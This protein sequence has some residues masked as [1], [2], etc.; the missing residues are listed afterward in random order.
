MST[1][2]VYQFF[3]RAE[4]DKVLFYKHHD[5]YPDGWFGALERIKSVVVLG[6]FDDLK[7]IKKVMLDIGAEE[8]RDEMEADRADQQ[9]RYNVR[10]DDGEVT[11]THYDRHGEKSKNHYILEHTGWKQRWMEK[12]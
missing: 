8:L 3:N 7:V 10:L 12:V 1:R 2:A 9:H 5:G 6:A 11:L 4:N